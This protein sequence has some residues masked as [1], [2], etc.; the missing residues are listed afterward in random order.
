[1][2]REREREKRKGDD[3]EP[4][5]IGM[6]ENSER[7]YVQKSVGKGSCFVVIIEGGEGGSEGGGGVR[8][9]LEDDKDKGGTE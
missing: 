2:K 4:P 3:R 7:V 8:R 5:P 6:K 1:M 9:S